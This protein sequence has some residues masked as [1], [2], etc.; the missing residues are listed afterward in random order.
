M[1]NKSVK[2]IIDKSSNKINHLSKKHLNKVHFIPR[3]YRILGGILQSMNIQFG[4]FIEVLMQN[5]IKGND[6]YRILSDY[7]GKKYKNFFIST[8]NE[9]RI[10][11][12]ITK[13]QTDFKMNLNNDFDR[14]LVFLKE[15]LNNGPMIKTSHDIDLLFQDKVD[16]KIYYVEIKYNDDHDTG[17]FIDIN[18]KLIKTYCY[19]LNEKIGSDLQI[20]PILFFFNNKKMKGNIYLPEDKV[21]YRGDRFFKKFLDVN[22]DELDNYLSNLSENDDTL[23]MFNNLYKKIMDR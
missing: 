4:N 17:K 11:E 13:C 10:D 8:K 3:K 1:I 22:Y 20:E 23:M 15:N 14:L 16:N 7:S 19:L 2:E 12:Y 6:R 5:L 21:I 18:R 9:Q